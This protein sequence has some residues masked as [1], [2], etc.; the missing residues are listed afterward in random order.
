M[1][2]DFCVNTGSHFSRIKFQSTIA[3]LYVSFIGRCPA[4]FPD[5][6][7]IFCA[8]ARHKQLGL[9][10]FLE[11]LGAAVFVLVIVVLSRVFLLPAT[12]NT[13]SCAYEPSQSLLS[14]ACSYVLPI[15]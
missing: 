6:C 5:G 15:L 14:K 10:A 8:H 2:T 7:T 3:G 11:A 4:V 9:S 1:C 12:L 13:F